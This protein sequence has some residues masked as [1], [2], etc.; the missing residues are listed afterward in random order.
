MHCSGRSVIQQGRVLRMYCEMLWYGQSAAPSVCT[1]P[2]SYIMPSAFLLAG[3]ALLG[4]APDLIYKRH[5]H[6]YNMATDQNHVPR[7]H[8]PMLS[9]PEGLD[10]ILDPEGVE[11]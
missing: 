1:F 5:R 10:R 7:V 11:R 2:G 8:V 4:D 3:K 6:K 9:D